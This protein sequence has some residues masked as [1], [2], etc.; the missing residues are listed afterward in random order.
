MNWFGLFLLTSCGGSSPSALDDSVTVTV[1]D[2]AADTGEVEDVLGSIQGRM[3]GA[4]GL[5]VAALQMRL[6]NDSCYMAET[7]PEGVF[8]FGYLSE[9]DYTLQAVDFVNP[10]RS[11]PHAIVSVTVGER[12]LQDWFIPDFASSA[13]LDQPQ[14]VVLDGGLSVAADSAGLSSGPYSVSDIA[15]VTSV[16][17]DP[18]SSGIPQ[19][20]L[21]GEIAAL[22]YLGTYDLQ[23]SPSWDFGGSVSLPPGTYGV[24]TADNATKSWIRGG[25]VTVDAMGAVTSSVGGLD[26]LTTLVMIEEVAK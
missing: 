9:G 22:W 17:V 2:S 19:D 24:W 11:T 14:T 15:A 20:G 10:D 5:G 3:I 6:C 4:D 25:S 12:V 18:L 1:A 7:D 13:A 8:S 23:I 16:M 21:V 26:R